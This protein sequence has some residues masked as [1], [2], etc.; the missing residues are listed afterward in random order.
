MR[1]PVVLRAYREDEIDPALDRIEGLDDRTRDQR[2]ERLR[3]SGRRYFTELLFAVEA[4]GRLVGE[5][6]ARFDGNMMPPGVFEVGIELWEAADR[7]RGFG[8]AALS[9]LLEH[10]FSAEG[11]ERVQGSTD[12]DNAAMRRTFESLGFGFEGVLR[13]F[14]PSED[15]RRDYASYAITR[16]DWS[17]RPA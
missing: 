1:P 2:R 3:A 10:L 12:L 17:R 14:M 8:S 6:Q 4:E 7:G 9:S 13:G 16:D 15:G 5:V 11:A